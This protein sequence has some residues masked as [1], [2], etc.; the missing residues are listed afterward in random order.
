[1][2]VC[3]CNLSTILNGPPS[4]LHPWSHNTPF[5]FSQLQTSLEEEAPSGKMIPLLTTF[6]LS[7]SEE[8]K[9]NKGHIYL[10][11][12]YLWNSSGFEQEQNNT[13]TL[14]IIKHLYL[15]LPQGGNNNNNNPEVPIVVQGK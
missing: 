8:E 14:N 7:K 6:I 11:S 13:L 1:M 3:E 10:I 12:L 15:W 5:W 9:R 4:D 2:T